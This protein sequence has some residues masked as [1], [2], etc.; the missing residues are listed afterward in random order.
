[1]KR[2]YEAPHRRETSAPRVP[3]GRHFERPKGR[4]INPK[5]RRRLNYIPLASY[6][7]HG[8]KCGI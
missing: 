7:S 1:M 2:I 4:L 5:I 6:L 3:C 8:V